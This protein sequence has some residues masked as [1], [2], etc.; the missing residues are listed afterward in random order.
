MVHKIYEEEA[1][2][3]RRIFREFAVGT[4]INALVA[5]LN[6]EKIPTKRSGRWNCSTVSRILKNEKYMGVWTWRRFKN[7]RD[8]NS[9]RRKQIPRD[10]K[11]RSEEHTSE[12]QSRLHLVC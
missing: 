9:G 3:V 12:L 8:P 6:E 2:I 5:R 11:E 7:V 1:D 10:K 4:S